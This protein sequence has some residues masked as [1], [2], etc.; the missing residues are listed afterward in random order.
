MPVLLHSDKAERNQ[1]LPFEKKAVIGRG[2]TCDLRLDD[3]HASRTH[4]MVYEEAGAYFLKDLESRNGTRLNGERV[5]FAHLSYGDEIRVGHTRL[6]LVQTAPSQMAGSVVGGYK[7]L[8]LLGVGGMGLVFKARRVGFKKPLAVKVLHPRRA[9]D[10]KL[11]RLFVEQA[12]AAARLF[13]PNLVNVLAAG[14]DPLGCYYAMDLVEGPSAARVVSRLGSLRPQEAVEL[15]IQTA[16]ALAHIHDHGLVHADV[17]PGNLLL[18][19]DGTAKLGDL[20]LAR[21][22]ASAPRAAD[23]LPDGRE[24]VWGTPAYMSP[25]VA[26]GQPP[27]PASDLYSLGATLFHLL[28]GKP[29]FTGAT[30]DE[31]LARHLSEPLPDLRELL[32]GLAPAI[33]PMVERLMAK[34]PERR[35]PGARNLLAELRTLREGMRPG[36]GP[37]SLK[38]LLERWRERK[39]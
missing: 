10:E 12:Q 26:T 17:K 38:D 22:A 27:T 36:G 24:C 20:A 35:Y 29:P 19:P 37:G 15:L 31:L 8:A 14:R 9:N 18:A 3:E 21:S 6:F 11:A 1:E 34:R 23:F 7:L 39:R 28:A 32:P 25:E 2:P 16:T 33:P 4:A 13:H 30:T 5:L